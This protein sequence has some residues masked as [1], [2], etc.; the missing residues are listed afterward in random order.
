M[1]V[2]F[3]VLYLTVGFNGMSFSSSPCY[4]R[5]YTIDEMEKMVYQ[6][7]RIKDVPPTVILN[8]ILRKVRFRQRTD[9]SKLENPLQD[10][11][12]QELLATK[13]RPPSFDSE[14]PR[15]PMHQ[16]P[17][18]LPPPRA[19]SPPVPSVPNSQVP[20]APP[21]HQMPPSRMMTGVFF[22]PGM[23]TNTFG[24]QSHPPNAFYI[25]IQNL[26]PPPGV[27]IKVEAGMQEIVF[28][29]V[30]VTLSPMMT[31]VEALRQAEGQFRLILGQSEDDSVISFRR[32]TLTECYIV[33]SFND[34][35]TD[36]RG[37]WK[38]IVSDKMGKDIYQSVCLP[39]RSEVPIK[40]G[41]TITLVYT[42]T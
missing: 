24:S 26:G 27:T 38:I 10:L 4:P 22:A 20:M 40:P 35:Q 6:V 36:E 37:Y 2:M 23:T 12:L 17:P 8:R 30:L 42:P 29:E 14:A 15:R 5:A 1:K 41:M 34:L 33:G 16:A 11:A 13:Y 32:S 9:K 39:S 31:A 18:A 25:P 21:M 28:P 7:A 19:F 3:T